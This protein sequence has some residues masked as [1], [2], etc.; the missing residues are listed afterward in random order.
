[1][2][3]TPS[4]MPNGTMIFGPNR[5]TKMFVESCAASTSMPIIGRNDRPVVIGE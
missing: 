1:M 5:G 2:P 3:I 4:V